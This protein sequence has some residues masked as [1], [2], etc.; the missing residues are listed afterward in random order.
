MIGSKRWPLIVV[1]LLGAHVGLMSWAVTKCVGDRNA[2]VIPNY[3]EK[4]VHYDD[5]KAE[6]AR[7]AAAQ[8]LRP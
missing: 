8:G 5:F 4:A 7:R 2:A 3:Y 1:A 6:R